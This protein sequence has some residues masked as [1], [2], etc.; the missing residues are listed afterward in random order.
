MA[1]IE[2]GMLQYAAYSYLFLHVTYLQRSLSHFM[3]NTL[4]EAA[5]LFSGRSYIP[6]Y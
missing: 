6:T 1:L 2:A 4:I 3:C 5:I